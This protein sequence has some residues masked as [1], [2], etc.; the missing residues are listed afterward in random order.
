MQNIRVF[1]AALRTVKL[2]IFLQ[3][4]IGICNNEK[5]QM[6]DGEQVVRLTKIFVIMYP[7]LDIA[8]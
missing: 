1:P 3:L 8:E 7:L 5:K 6:F 2:H 4:S